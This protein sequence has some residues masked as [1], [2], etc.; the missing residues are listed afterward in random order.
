[1]FELT[2]IEELGNYDFKEIWWKGRKYI[3]N[4]YEYSDKWSDFILLIDDEEVG[5]IYCDSGLVAI[6]ETDKGIEIKEVLA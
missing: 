6:V 2:T 3:Y 1:M 5:I 4:N